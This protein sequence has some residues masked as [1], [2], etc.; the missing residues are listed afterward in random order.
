MAD[1]SYSFMEL[2]DDKQLQ[3]E[4]KQEKKKKDDSKFYGYTGPVK[5]SG[6]IQKKS[7]KSYAKTKISKQMKSKYITKK[8]D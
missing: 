3:S 1:K 4:I 8:G 2:V 5:P 6:Y 7:N